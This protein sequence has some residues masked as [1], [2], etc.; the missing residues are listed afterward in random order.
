MPNRAAHIA[1]GAPTGLLFSAYRS[2][3][4]N[5]LATFLQCC[6]GLAG[7]LAGSL[8]PDFI[9]PP[10]FPGHRSIG[11]GVVPVALGVAG[12][13]QALD[14]WQ[15]ELRRLADQHSLI[16]MHSADPMVRLWHSL[17]ELALRLHSGM[18]AG[19]LAGYVSHVT[20]D[21]LTPN[22]LPLVS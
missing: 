7:G 13:A 2:H 3:G 8:T 17:A 6:G 14:S 11:H 12:L 4:Q 18:V 10:T 20:L 21:F 5:S 16:A 1:V 15:G 22:C 19:F 9:D